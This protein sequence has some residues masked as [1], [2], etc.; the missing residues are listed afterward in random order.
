MRASLQ[1]QVIQWARVENRA[2]ATRARLANVPWWGV[3]ARR[4]LRANTRR[5]QEGADARWADLPESPVATLAS[6]LVV[7]AWKREAGRLT[8]RNAFHPCLDQARHDRLDAMV[9][10][11]RTKPVADAGPPP[12]DMD[13]ADIPGLLE[14]LTVD[15]AAVELQTE[16]DAVRGVAADDRFLTDEFVD[17]EGN[18]VLLVQHQ[19]SGLR[20]EFALSTKE[21]GFGTVYS[22]PYKISSIDPANP[23]D[24]GDSWQNYAGLGIGTR[25]YQHA[26]QLHPEIRWRSGLPS[27]YAGAVRRKLH[28]QDPY[29]W[30][31]ASCSWCGANHIDWSN[32]DRKDFTGHPTT[33]TP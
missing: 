28:A 23:G 9:D 27:P 21:P 5:L 10:R 1:H 17:D 18:Q 8:N 22:K 11:L 2:R 31:C 32:V 25:I 12:C 19:A 15:H 3:F 33:T 29:T 6:V 16:A 4:D 20:A 30:Q 14:W 13:P 24:S 7:E 26:A